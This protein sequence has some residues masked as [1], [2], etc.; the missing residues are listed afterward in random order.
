MVH[1]FVTAALIWI[2]AMFGVC[3]SLVGG[4]SGGQQKNRDRLEWKAAGGTGEA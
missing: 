1:Y 4:G 3:G 2:L